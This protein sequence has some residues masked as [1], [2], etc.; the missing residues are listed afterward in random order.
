MGALVN[1]LLNL[2]LI[3]V[4]GGVGTSIATLVACFVS[5]FYILLIPKTR[6]QGVLMLKSLLLIS[7]IQKLTFKS[8]ASI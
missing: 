5:T 2:W 8:K 6:Q 1:I 3:P 7:L 4:Y